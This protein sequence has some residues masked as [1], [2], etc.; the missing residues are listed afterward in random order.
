MDKET[1]EKI[2]RL[3]RREFAGNELYTFTVILCDN[4]IDRDGERFSD[5]AVEQLAELFIG[6][7]GIFDHDPTAANQNARIYETEVVTDSSRLTKYG[8]PYKYLR[9]SAYMVRTDD[10]KA[11]IS[12]IDGGIKKEVSISCSAAK[13]IC[14]VCGC[15]ISHTDC[16]HRKGQDKC[17]VILDDIT[18]VY[19]WSFVAV[20]A[21]INAGVTKKYDPE[22]EEGQME[23]EFTPI[24]TQE[25]LDA[26][27]KSAV[28]AAVTES[29]ERFRDWVSPEEHRRQL[30]ELTAEKRSAELKC[31][32]HKA[33]AEAGLPAE[34]AE[35]LSGDSEEE[36]RKDAD[37]LQRS[38]TKSYGASPRFKGGTESKDPKTAA[39]L[40][41]LA[42]MKK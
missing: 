7:T 28:D 30:D 11:L 33:A 38:I 32:K 24:T 6:K 34:F 15:D 19:E 13:K 12:E 17:H 42:E 25:E 16:G 10:N 40:E 22:K 26:A 18:D 23:N 2:N 37:I 31:F 36:I 39:Q 9:A 21:Q 27:V 8:Q 14:S 3:T 4:D 41:M 29:E 5:A 35:R 20:P 1:L